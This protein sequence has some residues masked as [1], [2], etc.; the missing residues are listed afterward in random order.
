MSKNLR[1]LALRNA[2]KIGT[3]VVVLGATMSGSAMAAGTDFSTITA[4]I[5]VS[6]IVAALVGA[7]VILVG[8]GF[9]KWGSKKVGGF[10]G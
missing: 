6:T 2:Q 7:A 3:A 1:E 8:A 9:A 5:D 10:F 4:G